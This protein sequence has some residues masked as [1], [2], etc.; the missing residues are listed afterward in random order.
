MGKLGNIEGYAAGIVEYVAVDKRK[1]G[2]D[3]G[4]GPIL[5][6]GSFEGPNYGNL[7]GA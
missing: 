5:S 1:I 7:G 3:E 4:Y 2:V 6:G